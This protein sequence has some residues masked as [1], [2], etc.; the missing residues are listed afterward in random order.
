VLQLLLPRLK[1]AL[2][3]KNKNP[4]QASLMGFYVLSHS[5]D[6]SNRGAGGIRTLVQTSNV[7][8]FYMFSF[9]LVFD[10]CP[11][12]NGLTNA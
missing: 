12:G 3:S 5:T 4:K 11:A 8:A 1:K 9:R 6:M 10:A 2:V 7:S